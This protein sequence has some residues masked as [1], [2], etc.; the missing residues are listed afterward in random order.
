M[1]MNAAIIVAAGQGARMGGALSKQYLLLDGVPILRRTLDAFTQSE[2]F[3]EIIVVVASA[4]M[5]RCREH[6]LNGL[7]PEL[8]LRLVAGGRE[9]QES[10]FNGLEA[11][12]G[13]DDDAVLIHDGVRPFV[14]SEALARCL[15][16]AHLH[17]AGILAVPVRDTLKVADEDGCI[18]KTLDRAG[19][20]QA[21]TPQ[22]FRLGLIREAH[23]RAREDGVCGTDDAQLVERLERRVMIV[24]GKRINI[25]ITTPEDLSLAEAIWR[26]V[27]GDMTARSTPH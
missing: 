7:P 20:W 2:L 22:G 19:I 17:G 18:A 5:D 11:V 1:S 6:I 25:K 15:E 8:P 27:R 14:S 16:T 24:A 23:R 4:D 13:R 9:R 3:D 10:V 26:H 21:Q 12:N